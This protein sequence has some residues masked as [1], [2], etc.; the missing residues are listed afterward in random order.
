M[1][2]EQSLY[3]AYKI[4]PPILNNCNTSDTLSN[5]IEKKH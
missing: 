2:I 3:G 1:P 5:Q 4:N